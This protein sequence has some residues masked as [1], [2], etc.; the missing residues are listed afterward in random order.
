MIKRHYFYQIDSQTI[1]SK[2]AWGII[3]IKSW[4]P[5]PWEA[6]Q[7]ALRDFKVETGV[8]NRE[9]KLITFNKV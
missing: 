2:F 6:T 4:F 9:V 1:E 7:R 3:T 5:R 8:T